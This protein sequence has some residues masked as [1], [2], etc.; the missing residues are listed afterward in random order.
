MT[1]GVS[2]TTLGVTSR[3]PHDRKI[4]IFTR[5]SYGFGS[6]AYGTKDNGFNYFLLLFYSQVVGIDHQLVGFAVL[7][8]L[9]IDAIS[10]PLVGNW[11]D[12]F[13]SRWGR[14]HPFMY[15]SV[16]PVT[17]SYYL[18]WSPPQ[19][20]TEMQIFWYLLI[21]AVI[22]RTFI[23]FYETPSSALGFELTTDYEQRSTL[24]S[25]RYFFGWFG[26]TALTVSMYALVFVAFVTPT[27]SDGR[28]NPDSYKMYGLISAILI[29]SSIMI[30]SLGTHSHIPYLSTAKPKTKR[31]VKEILAEVRTM[32]WE[33]NFI[34]LFGAALFGAVATGMSAALS[35]ILYT[36]FWQFS[37]EQIALLTF[38]VFGSAII[39]STLAPFVTR[40]FGKKKSA[41]VIGLIAFL[42]SPTPIVLRLAGILPASETPFVFWFV[43]FTTLIDVGLIICF[44]ILTTSMMADLVEQHEIKTNKRA[45]G[46]FA[47]SATFIRKLV[48]GFGLITATTVLTLAQFPKGARPEDVA[49]EAVFRLGLYYVPAILTIWMIM[50]LILSFYRLNRED[51]QRNLDELARR[52]AAASVAE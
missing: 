33:R 15:L 9:I 20:W 50:M 46:I 43:F 39:G 16:I 32:F 26:G 42:G 41:I 11:S 38:G 49:P 37:S 1:E 17:V 8:A 45:E 10:D 47:A 31:Q 44:Q 40:K 18:L 24:I 6:V 29:F 12:N 27:I 25:F 51:H 21:L 30:S 13:R 36:Y 28:F 34:A 22:I 19:G 3:A 4:S 2:N 52:R 35:F 48:Q 7:I 23:T 5:L 14:R